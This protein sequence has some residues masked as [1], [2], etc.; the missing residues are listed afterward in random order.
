VLAFTTLTKGIRRER[1][2]DMIAH[3]CT[4]DWGARHGIGSG[5]RLHSPDKHLAQ[6]IRTSRLV[7][8]PNLPL[9]RA[10]CDS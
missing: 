2:I 3:G 7:L 10:R 9:K 6:V 4:P 5:K 8:A 1:A